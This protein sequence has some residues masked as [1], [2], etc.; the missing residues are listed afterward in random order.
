M[1]AQDTEATAKEILAASE[2]AP[3]KFNTE[4]L[5]QKLLQF[6]PNI[7]INAAITNNMKS[8]VLS[9][10]ASAL[11]E[12]EKEIAGG[13]SW[14]VPSFIRYMTLVQVCQSYAVISFL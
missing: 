11:K 1:L 9:A 3:D 14:T 6:F 7:N 4:K 5:S 8:S 10:T 13:G 2:V 12:K